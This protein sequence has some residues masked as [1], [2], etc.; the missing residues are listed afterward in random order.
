M[1]IASANVPCTVA[2]MCAGGE[3]SKTAQQLCDEYVALAR[4]TTSGLYSTTRHVTATT[5][6]N[7]IQSTSGSSGSDWTWDSSMNSLKILVIVLCVV[8]G[9]ALLALA[10]YFCVKRRNTETSSKTFSGIASNTITTAPG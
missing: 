1:I 10:I 3:N 2:Y 8:V 9:G 6:P 5:N 7:Y 4:D